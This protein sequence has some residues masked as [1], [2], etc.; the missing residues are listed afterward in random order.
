[1]VTN[2]NKQNLH[3]QKILNDEQFLDTISG[4]T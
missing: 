1:M 2:N 3:L 4:A